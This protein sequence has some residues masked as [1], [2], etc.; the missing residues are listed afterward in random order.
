MSALPN[1]QPGLIERFGLSR[2]DVDR[3]VWLIEPSGR[4]RRGAAAIAR[5]LSEMG[6]GWRFLGY[7]AVLPGSALAYRLVARSRGF[8]SRFW[9]D[10]PPY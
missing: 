5:V 7:L 2:D 6:G 4:R 9:S 3:W 1:Q 10:R 8:L